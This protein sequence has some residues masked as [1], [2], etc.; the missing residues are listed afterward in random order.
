MPRVPGWFSRGGRGMFKYP[1]DPW[2][3]RLSVRGLIGYCVRTLGR[4]RRAR[5]R[6]P[7]GPTLPD[8]HAR[9]G[10]AGKA[11]RLFGA[12]DVDLCLFRNLEPLR[13]S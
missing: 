13:F 10:P 3:R 7:G 12:A 2:G 11:G 6:R 1:G 8:E 4:H 5:R 9:P